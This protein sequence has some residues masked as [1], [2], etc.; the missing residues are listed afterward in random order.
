MKL[1]SIGHI[2]EQEASLNNIAAKLGTTKQSLKQV[3]AILK[4]KNYVTVAQSGTDKRAINI[5]IPKS[6]NEIM[7]LMKCKH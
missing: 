4:R 2:P 6:G 7:K 3:I 1:L 5:T